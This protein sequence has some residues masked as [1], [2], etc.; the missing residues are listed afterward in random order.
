[1]KRWIVYYTT[2]NGLQI[3]TN[4]D[5]PDAATARTN[6]TDKY[7]GAVVMQIYEVKLPRQPSRASSMNKR[8]L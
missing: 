6:I 8:R 3:R 5:A 7:P 4:T 2:T 1:M